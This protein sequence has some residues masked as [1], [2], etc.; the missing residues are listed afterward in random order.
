MDMMKLRLTI[1]IASRCLNQLEAALDRNDHSAAETALRRVDRELDTLIE[2]TDF[3][4]SEYWTNRLLVETDKEVTGPGYY[5]TLCVKTE[6]GTNAIQWGYNA[7]FDTQSSAENYRDSLIPLVDEINSSPP[8]PNRIPNIE[9]ER[10]IAI[11]DNHAPYIV[12]LEYKF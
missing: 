3:V 6:S 11:T 5:V 7:K 9:G 12:Y 2:E 1:E 10:I 4:M 8:T